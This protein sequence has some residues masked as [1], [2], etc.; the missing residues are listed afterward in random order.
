MVRVRG[1]AAHEAVEAVCPR[2][3]FVRTGQLLHSLVLDRAGGVAADLYVAPED[4][5]YLLIADGLTDAELAELLGAGTT[6]VALDRLGEAFVMTSLAGPYAGELLTRVAGPQVATFGYLTRFN[7]P[8][9]APDVLCMRAGTTGEYGY[10]L[11]I[12]RAAAA[13]V[14]ARLRELGEAFDLVEVSQQDVDHCALESG[15]FCPRHRGVLGRSPLELQLQWRLSPDRVDYRGAAGVAVARAHPPT[16]R[17]SWVIGRLEDPAPE[18]GPVTR[19]G[20]EVGELLDGFVSP[21]LGCFVGLALIDRPLAHPWIA[22]FFVG[23]LELR[24]EAPP[25]LQ[26]RSIFVDPRKHVYAH[27][28]EDRFPPIVPGARHG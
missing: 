21:M 22:E 14:D 12:P 1:S 26:N 9:L 11:L 13:E 20:V 25:L 6:G 18:P 19:D 27:R 8:E 5:D 28:D 7:L 17:L 16:R 4:D 15:F 10:D 2:D 24:T 23:D 3:L